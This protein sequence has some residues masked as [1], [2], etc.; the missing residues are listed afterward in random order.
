MLYSDAP[1]P[2]LSTVAFADDSGSPV[3][4]QVAVGKAVSLPVGAASLLGEA[5]A[6]LHGDVD[7]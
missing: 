5:A 6:E 3:L 1:R 2:R 7:M 4:M